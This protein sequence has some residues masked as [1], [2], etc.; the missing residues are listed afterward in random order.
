MLSSYKSLKGMR[1]QPAVASIIPML[2]NQ[3][4]VKSQRS[5]QCE[6]VE[7]LQYSDQIRMVPV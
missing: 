3:F 6:F 1:D 4:W 2:Q 7:D 5:V